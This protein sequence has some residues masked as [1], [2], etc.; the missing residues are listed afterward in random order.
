MKLSRPFIWVTPLFLLACAKV[1]FDS[2]VAST[3]NPTNPTV[4][5]QTR[6]IQCDLKLNDTLQSV[7]LPSTGP[8]P[9]VTAL[10]NPANVTYA[11]T[12]KKSNAVV[13]VP[14]LSGH[15]STPD[16]VS[17]GPGTYQIFLVASLN[18]WNSYNNNAAPLTVTI[19]EPP[20]VTPAL[21][22]DPKLNGNQTLVIYQNASANPT[23]AANCNPSAMTSCSWSV[24]H[25]G[26]PVTIPGIS[27]CS[28]TGDFSAAAPGDYL[29]YLTATRSGYTSY[30]ATNPL[31][32]RVPTGNSRPVTTTHTVTAQD[33]QLDILLV[34]D[35]SNSMLPDNQHLASKLQGFVNDLSSAGFDWQMCVTVTRAQQLTAGDPTL[36]WGA[37]RYWSGVTG[38]KPYILKPTQAN[39]YQVFQNTINAIGAGWAG[40]DDERGIKAAWWHVYNGDPAYPDASGCYRANAGFA[41][42]VISDEDERSVGGDPSQVYYPGE[43]R[44]LEPDD[45]PQTFVNYV[46]QVFGMQKRFAVNSIIVRPGDVSCMATQDAAGS[47]SHYGF[48][49]QEL[50]NLTGGYTGSICQADYSQNLR[51][52]RDQIVREMASLPL[53]CQPLPNT[54]TV[55]ITPGFS[56]TTRVEN[57][58]LY[59]D[60]KVPVGQTITASYR[61]P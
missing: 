18:G 42:I 35:D 39:T 2:K 20:I 12:V 13:S 26:M 5:P 50:S 44:P 19:N 36:Y 1:A 49:Y 22:C 8:N 6:T 17:V 9:K 58:V 53:E 23:Y 56:T 14:G 51:Y 30:V 24:M 28:G 40:T 60:P 33:N 3:P 41:T 15:T 31:T 57:G 16:F 10:C 27:G 47:K 48:K 54:L 7:T 61:C 32:V 43:L 46:K 25:N 11:W 34:V 38:P 4:T 37:S 52:F 29:M 21:V 55:T 59:F 45:E